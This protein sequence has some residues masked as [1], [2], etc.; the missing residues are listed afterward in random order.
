MLRKLLEQD[1]QALGQELPRVQVR[2][3]E[4]EVV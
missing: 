2:S 3:A 1:I 4:A